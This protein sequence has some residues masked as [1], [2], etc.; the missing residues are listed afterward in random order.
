MLFKFLLVLRLLILLRI[1]VFI[2]GLTDARNVP[3]LDAR[4]Q[5]LLNLLR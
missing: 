3:E 1:V 4:G 2:V 5:T